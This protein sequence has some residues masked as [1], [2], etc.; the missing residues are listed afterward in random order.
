M[1]R[2]IALLPVIFAAC[3]AIGLMQLQA[4]LYEEPQQVQQVQI[5]EAPKTVRKW[6]GV[7]KG[8]RA[9]GLQQFTA[10]GFTVWAVSIEAAIKKIC[11]RACVDTRHDVM[12][13]FGHYFILL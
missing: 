9:N 10:G 6:C 13:G 11:H 12:Q 3:M 8:V 2:F 5:G 7:R 1:K 4:P